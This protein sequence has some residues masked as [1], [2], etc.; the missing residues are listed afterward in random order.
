MSKSKKVDGV[1]E[2]VRYDSAGNILLVRAF[3]RRGATFSDSVL[4]NRLD[5]IMKLTN[6]QKFAIGER[7]AGKGTTFTLARNIQLAGSTGQEI[8]ITEGIESNHDDLDP[9]P[10]F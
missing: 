9:A 6:K 8:V 10:I 5:L 4:L 7:Q 1:I 2:A 3:E